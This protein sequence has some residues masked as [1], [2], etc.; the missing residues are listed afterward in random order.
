MKT[1]AKT[2]VAPIRTHEG[3]IAK[4]IDSVEQLKRSVMTCMLWEDGFYE[5]GVSVAD[6]ISTLVPLV[7]AEE[8]S[9]IA[10]KARTEQKLRHV[11][12]LIVRAMARNQMEGVRKTLAQVIQRPDE[13]TEFL[14]IYWKD[15][16]C[17]IAKQVKL[18]L[19]DAFGKFDEF[20][21]S[22]YNQ[23]KDIKLRDVMFLVHAKPADK[24]GRAKTAVGLVKKGKVIRGSVKRHNDTVFS[25]L[26]TDSLSVP[27]T[28][29]TALSASKDKKETWTRLLSED[30]LGAL[31]LI[32][33]LRNMNDAGVDHTAIKAAIRKMKTERVLP[34]RFISAANVATWAEPVLEEKM[35]ACLGDAEKLGGQTILLVDVSGSMESKV[36][37]KSDLRRLDAAYGLAILLRE[38]CSD[39]RI[40][41]FS[42][43]DIEIPARRG[44]ALRDAIDKSQMHGGTYLGKAVA[45]ATRFKPDR[46]IVISDE[47]TA[48]SVQSTGLPK[49]SYMLNVATDQ[50]GVG[51]GKWTN[52]SGWSEAVVSFITQL[53]KEN[54][55]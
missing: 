28:W 7:G 22:K 25:K 52:I 23:D 19:A 10:I 3:G 4:R 34:F 31:S 43:D 37:G 35:L 44:F 8:A 49:K 47:Q 50:N 14:S 40:F 12:L 17:P 53:E 5:N 51:Y 16:K 15:G 42:G 48:D 54:L 33:N 29:E 18:G 30:K 24:K 26:A 13:I 27:D 39:I 2:K 6:R 9:Q 11:P 46:L 55:T 36:S 45:N 1:N 41:S 20:T 21:L 38:I 32:R